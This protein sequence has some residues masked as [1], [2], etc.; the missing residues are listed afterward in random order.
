MKPKCLR[1]CSVALVLLLLCLTPVAAFKGRGF[2]HRFKAD[3]DDN[4]ELQDEAN[5]GDEVQDPQMSELA[6]LVPEGPELSS[7]TTEAP[8]LVSLVIASTGNTELDKLE[9]SVLTLAQEGNV[10]ADMLGFLDEIQV[11]LDTK[12]KKSVN[13]EFD[14]KQVELDRQCAALKNCSDTYS[15]IV[16]PL[17]NFDE[18]LQLREKHRVCREEQWYSIESDE[19]DRVLLEAQNRLHELYCDNYTHHQEMYV[20]GI[21]QCQFAESVYQAFDKNRIFEYYRDQWE[22]W[23]ACYDIIVDVHE[24][25]SNT[26]VNTTQLHYPCEKELE[27][28]RLQDQMDGLA[29]SM[30]AT[31]DEYCGSSGQYAL[32]HKEKVNMYTTIWAGA[33]PSLQTSLQDQMRAIL[34]IECYLKVFNMTNISAGIQ[35]CRETTALD[36]TNPAV[37][38]LTFNACD[39]GPITYT[40]PTYPG[41]DP[42]TSDYAAY[43]YKDTY[44]LADPCDVTP[45]CKVTAVVNNQCYGWQLSR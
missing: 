3:G 6:D 15:H 38:R 4:V 28:D 27:C 24:K 33:V 22:F 13:N 5:N 16:S 32:C 18:L 21:E 19:A 11:I 8:Q 31:W 30:R 45:C 39:T 40:C 10:S 26:T 23:Q 17:T 34:R 14:A 43:Y 25:C 20:D 44:G 42:S 9:Q 41:Q 7:L 37:F 12:M 29:C 2:S 1:T 36:H 35:G